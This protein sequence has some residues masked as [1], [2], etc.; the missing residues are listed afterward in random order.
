MD[1][2]F[3]TDGVV[4]NISR[5][6]GDLPAGW[7]ENPG[8]VGV[9]FI[10]NGDGTFS[11]PVAVEEPKTKEERISDLKAEMIAQRHSPITWD[12][13]QFDVN[14]EG[15]G[16]QNLEGAYVDFAGAIQIAK[17][18]GRNTN[19]DTTIPWALTDDTERDMNQADIGNVLT[20]I[21]KRAGALHY[22]Y[23]ADKAAILAE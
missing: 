10:D 20:E 11:E 9:G 15:E 23:R 2:I 3:V 6:S 8:G 5:F 22:Q 4:T 7:I 13:S 21:R 14:G 17:D 16:F 18:A 19:G 12:G 1:A